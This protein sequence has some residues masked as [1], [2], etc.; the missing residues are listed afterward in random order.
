[1]RVEL[2]IML[3]LLIGMPVAYG[4]DFFYTSEFVWDT[5]PIV[6]INNPPDYKLYYTIKGVKEWKE[7]LPS[8]FDYRILVGYH[9]VCNVNIETVDSIYDP[10]LS[11]LGQTNCEYTVFPVIVGSNI[12]LMN[13]TNWCSVVLRPSDDYGD[14]AK[15]E[16]G[17]VLG[18]GHRSIYNGSSVGSLVKTADIM[19]PQQFGNL[20]LS[21]ESL[22]V[23]RLI[24]GDDGWVEPNRYDIVTARVIHP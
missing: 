24:Y 23:L 10:F 17:H 7:R 9:E 1:M 4:F 12:I 14:T 11:P 16:M 15:H 6:C 13:T 19:L 20:T 8:G 18:V 21:E 2:S 22:A 5:A 3:I